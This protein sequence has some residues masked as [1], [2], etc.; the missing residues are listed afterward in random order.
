MLRNYRQ[1]IGEIKVLTPAYSAIRARTDK[2]ADN[3]HQALAEAEL[4]GSDEARASA[5]DLRRSETA[6]GLAIVSDDRAAAR[7]ALADFETAVG[8][9]IDVVRA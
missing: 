8:A 1:V 6:A 7:A 4:A 5:G 9:F 3:L 2:L